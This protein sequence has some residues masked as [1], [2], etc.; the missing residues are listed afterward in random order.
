MKHFDARGVIYIFEPEMTPVGS[1]HPGERFTVD[2]HDCFHE[3]I[4]QEDQTLSEIDYERLNPATGPIYIEGAEPGDLL[5]LTIHNIRIAENGVAMVVPG[6]GVLGDSVKE[7][8]IRIL[9]IQDGLCRF[10]GFEF[11][12]KPMIGVIGVAPSKA[13]GSWGTVS[14]W[15]HGGNMDTSEMTSGTVLYLPVQAQGA[16]LA[17]GDC[18]AV[19]GD[20][21]LC[22]TG[23]EVQARVE[24][25]ANIIRH[26]AQKWPMLETPDAYM[27]IASGDTIDEAIREATQQAIELLRQALVLSFEE[28]Y[29][30]ASL[31]VDLKFCQ[32]VDPKK[33]I[34]ASIPK[35][36]LTNLQFETVL[37]KNRD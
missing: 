12:I 11:P 36:V 25:T 30:L 15:M 10:A 22:F 35:F 29:M 19:M 17:L 18:H 27:V 32:V 28:A 26:A 16:L 3:Q 14:P 31:Y 5:K 20:G 21:E 9:P 33:T 2:T 37:S 7:G 6:E 8:I 24:L 23:L 4:F 1:V 13:S 34:R